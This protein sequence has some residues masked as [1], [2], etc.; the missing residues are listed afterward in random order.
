MKVLRSFP[1]AT[2]IDNAVKNLDPTSL[3]VL[4]KYIYKGFER[5]PRDSSQLLTWHEKV[6][7]VI[8]PTS[9]IYI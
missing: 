5:E 1:N 3:D 8:R 2:E 9:F 4:M 6:L 7:F